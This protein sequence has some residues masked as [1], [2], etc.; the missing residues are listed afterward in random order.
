MYKFN[1]ITS[2]DL[3]DNTYG[4]EGSFFITINTAN[5]DLPLSTI[6]SNK[7]I[8]SPA[9][10]IVEKSLLEMEK[11]FLN[12]KIEHYIIMPNHIHA[13]IH[14]NNIDLEQ[15]IISGVSRFE[16]S[17]GLMVGR[18]NPFLLKGSIFHAVTWF[19]ASS[20]IE[21]QKNNYT[22]FLWKSGYFDFT[23][24]N[25]TSYNNVA[26]YINHNPENW[27]DDLDHPENNY[28]SIIY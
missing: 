19:K 14:I 25:Q 12:L 11:H 23:I 10:K 9:G 27:E 2:Q 15:L 5:N 8:L 4:L 1:S 16:M 28:R 21:L 17:F 24:Q 6:K 22:K 18:L 3:I 20:L 26:K 13:L 7:V